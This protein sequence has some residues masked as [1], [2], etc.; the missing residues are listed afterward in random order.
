MEKYEEIL[1]EFVSRLSQKG[2]AEQDAESAE[3]REM[4][5]RLAEFEQRVHD[6]PLDA[7]T[8]ALLDRYISVSNALAGLRDEYLYAQG[9]KDYVQFLRELGVLK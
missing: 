3:A 4:A 2:V 1:T 7:E 5:D 9:A 6:A 8:K